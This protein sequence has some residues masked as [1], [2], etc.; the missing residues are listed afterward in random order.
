MLNKRKS[1]FTEKQTLTILLLVVFCACISYAQDDRYTNAMK[2]NIARI[3]S[4]NGLESIVDLTNSF[5]RIANAEKDKW[6]PY[7]YASF[8]S[9]MKSYSDTVQN[10]KDGHLDEAEKYF[11]IAD[12][13]Q[14][15]ESENFVLKAWIMM[16]RLQVDPMNRYM[17]YGAEMNAALEKARVLNPQ[18]PR[19]DYL[20]GMTLFYTPEAYGGGSKAAQSM[21]ESALKKFDEYV[22]KDDLMPGWGRQQVEEHLNKI[23]K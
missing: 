7:Y 2:S 4:V 1:L 11:T 10:N 13:L 5:T 9:I 3:D 14:P 18:N 23:P 20:Q 19:P 16:S 15:N 12:S 6:L 22:P 21:L 8:L 17:K